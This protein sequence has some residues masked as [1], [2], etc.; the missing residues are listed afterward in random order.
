MQQLLNDAD[1]LLSLCGNSYEDATEFELF[2]RCLSE[3]TIVEDDKRRLR[4]KEDGTMNSTAL[5]NSSDPEATF[6]TKAGKNHRDYAA[7]LEESVGKNGS[8]VTDYAYE[9]KSKTFIVTVSS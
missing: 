8:V 5:Q 4:T 9:Q 6:R 1:S 2:I 7:N 3:Q